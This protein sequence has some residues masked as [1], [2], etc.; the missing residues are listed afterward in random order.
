MTTESLA[1]SEPVTEEAKAEHQPPPTQSFVPL[2]PLRVKTVDPVLRHRPSE[3]RFPAGG[4]AE[5]TT[6]GDTNKAS[7]Q[8]DA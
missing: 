6:T 5:A 7:T 8:R 4:L 3:L 1:T 2:Y